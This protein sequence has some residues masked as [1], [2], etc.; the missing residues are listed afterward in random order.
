MGSFSNVGIAL[1]LVFGCVLLALVA[2]ELYYILWWKRIHAPTAKPKCPLSKSHD[3][4][5]GL[6]LNRKPTCPNEDGGIETE[7]M[8]AHNLCGP[9]RF[10]F[11]IK[12][13]SKEDLDSDCSRSR[14]RSRTRSLSDIIFAIDGSTTPNLLTPLSSPTVRT[15]RSMES[16][17]RINPLFEEELEKL[18]SSP[19]PKFKFLKDA[20]D[21][22]LKR[23]LIEGKQLEEYVNGGSFMS[24]INRGGAAPAQVLP[25]V[26]SPNSQSRV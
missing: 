2:A 16:S 26:S 18:R 17:F 23:I 15:P 14:S 6:T 25:L 7:L 24:F 4:E 3:P 11:T 21:K 8:R 5:S 10:L 1:C 9:P 22:F 12:E 13:E 20:E 19:P